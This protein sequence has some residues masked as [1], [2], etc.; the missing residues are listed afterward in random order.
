LTKT[1]YDLDENDFSIS[2][3]KAGNDYQPFTS[4]LHQ[5]PKSKYQLP[6]Q[7]LFTLPPDSKIKTINNNL[8]YYGK[9]INSR[10]SLGKG[11]AAIKI[12]G[13]QSASSTQSPGRSR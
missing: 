6:N 4:V 13:R 7:K 3:Y 12:P 5:I 8:N 1:D 2:A 10:E 11:F 9:K